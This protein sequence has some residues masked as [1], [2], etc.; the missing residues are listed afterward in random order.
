ML[1]GTLALLHRALRLDSRLMTSHLLRFVFALLMYFSLI[2]AQ[3][4]SYGLA[5]APGLR[6]FESMMT[7]NVALIVL[8]G[9]S[10]FATAIT[11]EKEEETL[12][13]LKMAGLNPL[14][15]LLG[16]ST[17][18]LINT[19][20]LLGVQFPFTLLA[21]TL[22]GA[23]V[24]QIV[25][26]YVA[27]AAFLILT[28]NVGLLASV[29]FRRGGTASWAVLLFYLIYFVAQP[30][31]ANVISGLGVPLPAG[32]F[33]VELLDAV[34]RCS[35][36][37]R[38]QEIFSTG[39]AGP[40]FELQVWSNCGIAL[41]SF[42]LAWGSF[43][44]FTNPRR[45]AMANPSLSDRLSRLLGSRRPRPRSQ[46]VMWKEYQFVTGGSRFLVA[47]FLSYF[48]LMVLGLI[49]GAIYDKSA[50]KFHAQMISA[51]LLGLIVVEACFY[52]SRLLHDEWREHTLPMLLMLPVPVHRILLAKLAGCVPA[53]IPGLLCLVISLC[54][55]DGGL[56]YLW[57]TLFL[58]SHW[59]FVIVFLLMLTLTMFFSLVV[60]W[61]ALP[62]AIAVM[63]FASAFAG[64]CFVPATGVFMGTNDR[65]IVG[66][67]A[68]CAVVDAIL[69]LLILAL[70]FD[71]QRRLE[72]A[73]AQ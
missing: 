30:L 52:A 41:L 55:W 11:E 31:A 22:G 34:G 51:I 64:C 19:L 17:S 53:L 13:L 40:V 49:L 21:V 4:Q 65:S 54:F 36:W 68:A 37:N 5:A 61:G 3:I 35:V 15:L 67:E 32:G 12:G 66:R 70:Q 7:L 58:P 16:K 27:L 60:R 10:F 63:L 44:H 38:L 47:R 23:T 18:R 46:P 9:I 1:T 62:L 73:G 14:G 72:I 50:F 45:V 57:N 71:I 33:T 69:V 48:V 20:L 42:L 6:L 2:F 25:A 29:A 43:N 8:A 26:G 39:F 59:M 28:A 56:E 24:T